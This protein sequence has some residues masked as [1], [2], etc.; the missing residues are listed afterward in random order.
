MKR[1]SGTAIALLE[2]LYFRPIITVENVQEI[3]GLSSYGNANDLVKDLC[4]LGLLAETTGQKRNRVFAY[5][6]I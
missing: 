5:H 6:H 3:T 2:Q 4:D 1:K